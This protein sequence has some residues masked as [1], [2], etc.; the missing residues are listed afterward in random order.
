M[1]GFIFKFLE[2]FITTKYKN[3]LIILNNTNLHRNVKIKE[4]VVK[5]N[6]LLYSVPY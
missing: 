3:K 5:N 2:K 4:L 1:L 6:N